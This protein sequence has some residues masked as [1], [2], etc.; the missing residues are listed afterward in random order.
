MAGLALVGFLWLLMGL[1]LLLHA[2]KARLGLGPLL[3]LLGALVIPM[4]SQLG[5]YIEPFPGFIMFISSNVF[6]P[7][8][9]AAALVI[10]VA[11]GT[12]LA[13]IVIFGLLGLSIFALLL[14]FVYR[15]FLSLPEGGSLN[16]VQPGDLLPM[17]NPRTTVASLLA[18][19]ADMYVIAIFYQGVVNGFKRVPRWAVVGLALLAALWSDAI[20]FRI[21]ADL[22]TQ[23]F[24]TLLPGDL[25]GKTT[26]ALLLWPLCAYYLTN[27]APLTPGHV[28]VED[29]PTFDILT[30]VSS[31]LK[32]A[33]ERTQAALERVESEKAAEEIY[34]Q[35]IIEN[36]SQVL[37][38]ADPETFRAFYVN[39]AFER[40]W[41]IS[42]QNLYDD[43]SAFLRS[44][45]PDDRDRYNA[46][47][48]R[49]RQGPHEMEYRIVRPDGGARWIRDHT[50]PIRNTVGQIYRIVGIAEDITGRVELENQKL[51]LALERERVRLLRDFIAEA[52]HDLKGPL[53]S[54]NLKIHQI[55]RADDTKTRRVHLRDLESQ[56]KRMGQM[57]DD[58]LTLARLDNAG[59]LLPVTLDAAQLLDEVIT[60][61]RP[62][63]ETKH[64]SIVPTAPS[65][66]IPLQA[67]I[68]DLM[69]AIANLVENAV[70]YTPEG[71]IVQVAV[72]ENDHEVTL[73]VCDNGIGIAEEDLPRIFERFFRA[74]NAHGSDSSGTGL[75]LVI[76]QKVVEKHQ[77]IISVDSQ[78]GKGTTFTIVLPKAI[79][80]YH[81]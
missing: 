6:V 78:L 55:D 4:A 52:S 60:S 48:L 67:D 69:R 10:Y 32:Q 18:F 38:L 59:A 31:P 58:L 9:L 51:E 56:S 33:L 72:I 74:P 63:A 81:I 22:G 66:P 24:I 73:Q 19:V 65:R 57:I 64:I 71:G 54:M 41:G 8:L 49:R 44:I 17:A 45:H 62:I 15:I 3:L 7:V 70:N 13:R 46:E 77:G 43:E 53:T 2:M 75:G 12:M 34:H 20:I 25:I 40:I 29:R 26:S 68:P 47:Q 1:V 30:G 23:D 79:P 76:V 11:D 21:L 36:I 39:P 61:I 27:I 42:A 5:I 80:L 16:S 35:Q 28:G 50:F 37:W 14:I